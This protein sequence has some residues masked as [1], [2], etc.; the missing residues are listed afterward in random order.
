MI[1][2]TLEYTEK[3]KS[4]R[5][6]RR[7]YFFYTQKVTEQSYFRTIFLENLIRLDLHHLNVNKRSVR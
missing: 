4:L 6:A 3:L 2:D 5:T 7:R 1:Q